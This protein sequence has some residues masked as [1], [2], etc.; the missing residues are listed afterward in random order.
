[1]LIAFADWV[2][3]NVIFW[4][5]REITDMMIHKWQLLLNCGFLQY[6]NQID[7]FLC[8]CVCLRHPDSVH[9]GSLR[10]SFW[11]IQLLNG[12]LQPDSR[13]QLQ[14]LW[15]QSDLHRWESHWLMVEE[16]LPLATTSGIYQL[17]S[18]TL[19]WFSPEEYYSFSL[20]VNFQNVQFTTNVHHFQSIYYFTI[21][22][23]NH[24]ELSTHS[25]SF[26]ILPKIV[27]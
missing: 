6:M 10:H 17:P 26:D 27:L 3:V 5:Y 19:K 1:M 7:G 13:Q 4:Y 8:V 12:R 20:H 2:T 25:R 18:I 21:R 24:V 11:F 14:N 16:V 22:N 15:P 9:A 23:H